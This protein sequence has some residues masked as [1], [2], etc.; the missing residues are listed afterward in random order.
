MKALIISAG[1]NKNPLK[2]KEYA[3]VSDLVICAD[4]GYLYAYSLNIIPDVVIGDFDSLD[5][6]IP[7]TI[8]KIT[9]PCEKDETDTEYAFLYAKN[10]GVDEIIIYGGLGGRLDH[11]YANILL[12]A[13]TKIKSVL[14]DGKTSCYMTD[15]K[16]ELSG[17]KGEYISVFSFS[18]IS[19]GVSIK[20]LKYELSDYNLKKEDVL[21]VS[22]EFNGNKAEISV[23]NGKLLIICN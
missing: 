10:E 12:L 23:K 9:L 8:K 11:T 3:K 7:D 14:T 18:D 19:Y 4:G 6:E 2:L 5:I 15:S 13:D 1:E 16:L 22:N 20:G 21:G 17:K